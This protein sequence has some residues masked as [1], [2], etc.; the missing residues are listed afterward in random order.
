MRLFRVFVMIYIAALACCSVGPATLMAKD[1]N[2]Q[3]TAVFRLEAVKSEANDE[4]IVNVWGENV[5]DVYAFEMDLGYEPRKLELVDTSSVLPGMSISPIPGNNQIRFAHTQVGK[6]P[7][8]SG[9]LKLASFVFK[10]LHKGDSTIRLPDIS[11]VAAD[12]GTTD[13]KPGNQLRVEDTSVNIRLTDIADHWAEQA[14]ERA[15]SLGFV[16]GYPDDT[17]RPQREVTRG[18]FVTLLSRALQLELSVDAQSPYEDDSLFPLWAKSHIYAATDQNL[19][20]GYEDRNFHADRPITRVEMTSIIA[21]AFAEESTTVELEYKDVD[22]IP[23]WGYEAVAK[24]TVAGLVQGK[25]GKQFAP[26]DQATRVEAVVMI[27]NGLD[28]IKAGR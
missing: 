11:L 10:Q 18:E 14:I 7:G 26:N 5:S 12:L 19:I 21:R 13:F 2:I 15:V 28:K 22:Q 1:A 20:V 23:A 27:L 17:F 4:I 16:E 3:E 25:P 6:V 8:K 24:A 9:D